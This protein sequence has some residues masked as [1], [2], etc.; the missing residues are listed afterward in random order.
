MEFLGSVALP[1]LERLQNAHIRVKVER[2]SLLF[3]HPDAFDFIERNAWRR[4]E[5]VLCCIDRQPSFASFFRCFD[6]FKRHS[7]FLVAYAKKSSDRNNYSFDVAAS[8]E[9][10]IFNFADFFIVR[11]INGLCVDIGN[12]QCVLWERFQEI[13]RDCSVMTGGREL[14]RHRYY[15]ESQNAYRE[16]FFHFH[17]SIVEKRLNPWRGKMFPMVKVSAQ[18]PVRASSS[19]RGRLRSQLRQPM[20]AEM[21]HRNEN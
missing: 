18:S 7:D 17:F 6:G 4:L 21:T 1:L 11:I 3:D 14:R 15:K 16:I 13:A 9:E 8:I 20:P 19:A 2:S 10:K 12:E 5:C